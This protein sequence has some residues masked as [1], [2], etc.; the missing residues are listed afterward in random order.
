MGAPTLTTDY[1][2]LLERLSHRA[3][4][5][6]HSDWRMR[7]DKLRRLKRALLAR[8]DAIREA[9]Y[10][11]F[12]KP[13]EE[14]D[15]TELSVLLAEISHAERHV[16][17]WMQPRR[18]RTPVPFVGTS[19]V[20]YIEP[21]GVV[22][23]L[24][25]WNYPIMLALC[26]VASAIA[27]GNTVVLKP[28]ELT[29]ASSTLM[30]TLLADVFDADEVAV[31]EGDG[32][33]ARELLT[34]RFDHIFFTGSPA[35]G[36]LVMKAAAR[37][38]TSVTLELGGKSPA[39]VDAS[40]DV[41]LTARRLIFGKCSNAGQTCVTPDYLLV[42]RALYE[43]LVQALQ[44]TLDTFYGEAHTP[45]SYAS[46]INERHLDRLL[47]LIDDAVAHGARIVRGGDMVRGERVLKPT[48]IVD[49]PPDARLLEEEIFGPVLPIVPYDTLDEALAFI[50][51]RPP[52]LTLYLF[53][54]DR[55]L[56]DRVRQQTTTGSIVVNDT[57]IH[58]GHT[59][60]AFGGIHESGIGR[61]HGYA[62]FMAFSNERPLL[63][64]H[65]GA[66]ALFGKLY[67]PY[68]RATRWLLNILLRWYGR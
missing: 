43:P 11:D 10:T 32:D 35:I 37:H 33:V 54:S 51:E 53:S 9:V 36:R 7:V 46:I 56:P 12:R 5:I 57:L 47:A 62:G 3:T 65:V 38:L 13:P 59:E 21:K 42:H 44:E 2:A 66:P 6:R 55:S 18:L 16:R 41:T 8:R 48:L 39:L 29:P 50:N 23:V 68:T 34:L 1:A 64:Q 31:V 22:L 4:E 45:A 49:I 26:P 58:F 17:Q 19:A 63:T 30:R 24:A 28:S 15:L 60:M 61:S 52:A 67:P 20:R 25:P 40:A 27:A 14:A